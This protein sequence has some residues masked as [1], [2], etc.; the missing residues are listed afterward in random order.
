M[1][2]RGLIMRMLVLLSLSM[3]VTATAQNRYTLTNKSNSNLTVSNVL[4]DLYLNGLMISSDGNGYGAG[5]LRFPISFN[6][7]KGDTLMFVVRSPDGQC[8]RL[9]PIYL[10]CGDFTKAVIAN[11]GFV[12]APG[13]PG[14]NIPAGNQGAVQVWHF[15]IPATLAC[16]N[17]P[18]TWTPSN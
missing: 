17:P 12:F 15:V 16:T 9:D 11:P 6:S 14:C 3:T 18:V 5:P 2:K 13:V 1:P 8:M 10:S 4:L 7:Q